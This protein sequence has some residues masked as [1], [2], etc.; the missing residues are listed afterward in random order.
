MKAGTAEQMEVTVDLPG[1]GEAAGQGGEEEQAVIV[2]PALSAQSQ[3]R[4]PSGHRFLTVAVK[5]AICQYKQRTPAATIKNV[6]Q[7][8]HQRFGIKHLPR[9]TVHTIISDSA[10]YL[11]FDDSTM[12]A[13]TTMRLRK[14]KCDKMENVLFAWYKK[15]KA[16]G[17]HISDAQIVAVARHLGKKLDVPQSFAYSNGWLSN[18]KV[19]KGIHKA[20][21]KRVQK[22][23]CA[24]PVSFTAKKTTFDAAATTP[25]GGHF[26][27]PAIDDSQDHSPCTDGAWRSS[28]LDNI[29]VTFVKTTP[30]GHGNSDAF[31]NVNPLAEQAF[32]VEHHAAK[33]TNIKSELADVKT[34]NSNNGNEEID[35]D[36]S[37][38][39]VLDSGEEESF[40]TEVPAKKAKTEHNARRVFKV[41]SLSKDL[42]LRLPVAGVVFGWSPQKA[43]FLETLGCPMFLFNLSFAVQSPTG[44]KTFLG[45]TVFLQVQ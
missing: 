7:Y 9:S 19:R 37:G 18:W 31:G 44:N 20:S 40:L 11:N 2:L 28:F 22:R 13:S 3:R 39:I 25:T 23:H 32:A 30:G 12:D 16:V 1:T 35:N 6:Q 45:V 14:G 38:E 42:F 10:K 27:P 36:V 5:R 26:V 8:A 29:S 43:T 34:D 33:E 24:D 21:T 17:V 15:A 41:P 4:R